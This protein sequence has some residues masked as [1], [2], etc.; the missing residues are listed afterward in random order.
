M[1]LTRSDISVPSGLVMT[2]VPSLLLEL[3]LFNSWCLGVGGEN[4]V[5]DRFSPGEG[6]GPG[7]FVVWVLKTV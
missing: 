7:G 6:M 3:V 4:G 1:F 5:A 2:V